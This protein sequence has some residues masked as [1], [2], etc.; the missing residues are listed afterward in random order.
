VH[1]GEV[2]IALYDSAIDDGSNSHFSTN[3]YMDVPVSQ[4]TPGDRRGGNSVDDL[5]HPAAASLQSEAT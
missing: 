2:R 5:H 4:A 3:G 1:F